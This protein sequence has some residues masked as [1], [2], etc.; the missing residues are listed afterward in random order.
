MALSPRFPR[1]AQTV[2]PGKRLKDSFFCSL[3]GQNQSLLGFLR[4][5][6]LFRMKNRREEKG[7]THRSGIRVFSF[8]LAFGYW[9][10]LASLGAVSACCSVCVSSG[11]L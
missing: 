9:S 3:Y 10:F 8:P 7:S 2:I 1:L 6:N 4:L 11:F 5:F